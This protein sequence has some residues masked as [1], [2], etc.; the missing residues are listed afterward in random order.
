MQIKTFSLITIILFSVACKKKVDDLA[1]STIQSTACKIQDA[2]KNPI[3]VGFSDRMFRVPSK[4]NIKVGVIFVDFKDAV[5]TKSPKEIFDTYISPNAEEYL[6]T[7]SY[8]NLSLKFEPIFEW[9]RMSKSASSYSFATYANHR[10]YIQEAVS[11]LD[12]KLDFSKYD[13]LLIINDPSN[14]SSVNG[15]SFVSNSSSQGILVDGKLIHN[16]ATSGQD[17][18]YWPKGL[19]FCHEF[20]HNLGLVDLYSYGGSIVHGFVGDYSIMGDIAG[21]SPELLGWERWTLNWL[22]DNQ[23]VCQGNIG[24]GSLTL[25]PIETVGGIK[26]L[27]I[28]VDQNSILVVESRRKIGYDRSILKEGPLVYLVDT[29]IASGKCAIKIIPIDEADDR[30]L[31]APL[32]VSQTL[33]YKNIKI[34]YS[35]RN[36]SGDFITFE[37]K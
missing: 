3:V 28:P 6:K 13:Q 17:L 15:P 22:N 27:T 16:A 26:L 8:N 36:N 5:A 4:G 12:P 29:S 34:T 35:S 2:L 14:S 25:T 10:S 33:T 37:K 24:N 7:V 1:P 23:V 9:V 11:L 20:I 21:S 19:W 18:I 31:E 30:K 32:N